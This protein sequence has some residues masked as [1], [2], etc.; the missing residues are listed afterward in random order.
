M[1]KGKKGTE[2]FSCFQ[3]MKVG[4]L[5]G[6]GMP[7]REYARRADAPPREAACGVRKCVGG[8]VLASCRR[9]E[10]A[11]QDRVSDR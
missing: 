11:R 8:V 4:R 9:D 10:T 5:L 1:K 7:T 6:K 3:I 2:N